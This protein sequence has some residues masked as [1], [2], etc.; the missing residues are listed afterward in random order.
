MLTPGVRAVHTCARV[1]AR[2]ARAHSARS[3]RTFSLIWNANRGQ[4]NTIAT[5]ISFVGANYVARQVGYQMTEGWTQGDA[6]ANEYFRPVSTFAERFDSMLLD[7]KALG[8]DAIDIWSSHL[9][10]MWATGQRIAIARGLLDRHGMSVPSYCGSLGNTRDE[11][12]AACKHAQAMDIGILAGMMPLPAEDR[13]LVVDTLAAHNVRL[14]VE[15]HPETDPGQI[16]SQIGDGHGGRLGT[17]VDTGWW[18][19]NGYDAAQAISILGE[20][21]L[22][23][24]LKD[25]RAPGGHDTCRYGEGCVPIEACVRALRDLGYEG[26]YSVEHEPDTFDPSDDCKANLRMLQRWLG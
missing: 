24:H 26:Y 14:A 17:A 16:L 22:A 8:F 25:V 1:C 23:V 3:C 9:H 4:G 21:V 20:H 5:R 15:N 12:E 7:V 11:F 6:A 13:G 18:G 10:W 19:T 2:A